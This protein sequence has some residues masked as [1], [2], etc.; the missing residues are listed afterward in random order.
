MANRIQYRR[1][2]A[3]NFTA[4]NTLLALGEPAI[5]TDTKRRKIG[6]GT[7]PWT[8]LPY[9]FDK[10][11]A[12]ASYPTKLQTRQRP[13]TIA[14]LGDSIACNGST[15]MAVV[16]LT[17]PAA[18][19]ATTITVTAAE[20]PA[21]MTSDFVTGTL[22][23]IG[24]E[25]SATTGTPTVSGS[26]W[27][28]TLAA[29]L[30]AAHAAG[31]QV[32]SVPTLYTGA[33]AAAFGASILSKG[34][35]KFAGAYG[36]GGY[37]AEQ[38]L[39][40]YVPLVLAAKP[41]YCYVMAGRN[42]GANSADPV[43]G[44]LAV[45]A[46]WDA[47]LAGGVMPIASTMP[48]VA[49]NTAQGRKDDQKLNAILIHHARKRGIPLT[50]AFAQMVDPTTGDFKSA[51]SDMQAGNPHPN[52]AGRWIQAQGIWD[53]ISSVVPNEPAQTPVTNAYGDSAIYPLPATQTNA[54]MLTGG[55]QVNGAGTTSVLPA[56]W[57]A[58]LVDVN[59]LLTT[60]NAPT[61]PGKAIKAQR[62]AGSSSGTNGVKVL[63]TTGTLIPGHRYLFTCDIQTNGLTAAQAAGYGQTYA[64]ITATHTDVSG[65]QT[66]VNVDRMY[67]DFTGK[68][69]I[70]F[71]TSAA[72]PTSLIVL[73]SLQG[74]AASPAFDVTMWNVMVTDLTA[75]GLAADSPWPI[76]PVAS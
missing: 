68:I 54:L 26:T 15:G 6:D 43:A 48:P 2:T 27:T 7:T 49:G 8:S 62:A 67:Q 42:A 55:G 57:T 53:A 28:I 10:S 66:F 38:M 11:D 29:G 73:L 30:T 22:V 1:D 40:L 33:P 51:A 56:G 32:L 71:V 36:H 50:D 63:S 44:A 21:V 14:S 52:D 64:R 23:K 5:E 24:S 12:D 46:L 47:L 75:L 76:Q 3:A 19:G 25:Y 16:S 13:A 41:G 20:S 72:Q 45:V 65:T 31:E 39:R 37:N 35:L 58:S 17:A 9:Q 34:R 69:Y 61:G 70:D 4:A 74:I 18:I 60:P 59:G